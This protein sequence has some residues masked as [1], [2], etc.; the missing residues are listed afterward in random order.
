M[1]AGRGAVK[2]LARRRGLSVEMAARQLRQAFLARA[3]RQRGIGTVATAHHADDQVE[4]FFLRVLRGAG[5]AG[6][7]G[8]KWAGSPADPASYLS[9]L[10][11]ASRNRTWRSLRARRGSGIPKTRATPVWTSCATGC[12]MNCCPCCGPSISPR[13]P[14]ASCARWNWR[15][16]RR[17]WSGTWLRNGWPAGGASRW[18]ACPSRC[19]GKSSRN[20]SI[21]SGSRWILNWWRA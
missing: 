11:S 16:R 1:A 3:A 18:R 10:C 5:S 13:W 14:D 9:A 4:L 7:A 15:G 19:N 21:N 6:L 20:N 2:T 17:S 8:M 12:G